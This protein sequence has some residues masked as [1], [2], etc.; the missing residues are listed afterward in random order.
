[1]KMSIKELT[2]DDAV[3]AVEDLQHACREIETL[4]ESL[5]DVECARKDALNALE[6]LK[7]LEDDSIDKIIADYQGLDSAD[8]CETAQNQLEFIEQS[9]QCAVDELDP[10]DY[11]G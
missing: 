1:M 9:Y 5:N 10:K 8:N 6:N 7:V 2:F 11:D 3:E 4:M